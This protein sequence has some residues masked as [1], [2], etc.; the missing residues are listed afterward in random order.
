[1]KEGIKDD[2]VESVFL[3]AILKHLLR[4]PVAHDSKISFIRIRVI[5]IAIF[6][7]KSL[8]YGKMD[9]RHALEWQNSSWGQL[10][11]CPGQLNR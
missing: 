10:F 4:L 9:E 2:Q 1:M 3:I 8:L 7:Q 11:S 6:L 5:V